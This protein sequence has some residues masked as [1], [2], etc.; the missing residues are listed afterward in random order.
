MPA[1]DLPA[2][3]LPSRPSPDRPL[4]AHAVTARAVAHGGPS[5]LSAAWTEAM[6]AR[7]RAL[8]SDPSYSAAAIARLL[9]GVSRSAVL[10]KVRR[11]GLESRTGMSSLRR[12]RTPGQVVPFR[13]GS[14]RK[15]ARGAP[16]RSGFGVPFRRVT[17]ED[18]LAPATREFQDLPVEVSPFAVTLAD[19][20][21]RQCRWPLGDPASSEFRFCGARAADGRPYC[22]HHRAMA[23][24]A[25]PER[26]ASQPK[27]QRNASQPE[28][29][30][31]S[32]HQGQPAP[33]RAT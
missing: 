18:W 12:E 8:W 32:R 24:R 9:G 13:F 15:A 28:G 2:R 27:A 29:R 30:N 23:Y 7:L 21:P 6:V 3:D 10:G 4:S 5:A 25:P 1:R 33:A 31:T 16:R 22:A 17:I 20:A 11:L 19:L 26:D 14:P